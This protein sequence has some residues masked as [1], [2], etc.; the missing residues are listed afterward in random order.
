MVRTRF[1]SYGS[2]FGDAR[3]TTTSLKFHFLYAIIDSATLILCNCEFGAEGGLSQANFRKPLANNRPPDFIFPP[4][5]DPALAYPYFKGLFF[6][7]YE[8]IPSI[9]HCLP[10]FP[11]PFAFKNPHALTGDQF[12]P[13]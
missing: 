11:N 7:L 9:P 13:F 5:Y 2:D 10:G 3:E 12:L 8:N 1:S 6:I 4:A